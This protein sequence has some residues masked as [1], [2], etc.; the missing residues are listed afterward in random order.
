MSNSSHNDLM[1]QTIIWN[2]QIKSGNHLI[3]YD[4]KGKTKEKFEISS[5]GNI[6]FSNNKIHFCRTSEE[7]NDKIL[8]IEKNEK[9]KK[10]Y[11]DCKQYLKSFS[12]NLE[13]YGAF[14]AYRSNFFKKDKDKKNKFYR[15]DK[16]DIIK[17]GKLYIRIV[18]IKLDKE[19][20]TN[21]QNNNNSYVFQN[22]NNNIIELLPRI[23]SARELPK[24]NLK[25]MK[26]KPKNK[27]RICYENTSTIKNPLINPCKCKGSMKYIHYNCL[28]N[29]IKNKIEK[30]KNKFDIK[31]FI[32]YEKSFLNCELCKSNF[33][34]Y[35]KY[36]NNIYNIIPYYNQFKE[37][38]LFELMN[39]EGKQT[40]NIFSL[41]NKNEINIG[42]CSSN[43]ICLLE[44]TLSRF[45]SIIH[46]D[47][48]KGELYIED[49]NSRFGTLV[50]IQSNKIEINNY[51]PLRLE[52]NSVCIKI[53]RKLEKP[54]SLSCCKVNTL[55]NIEE[56]KE[57]QNQNKN[58]I[59]KYFNEVKDLDIDSI[60]NDNNIE[61]KFENEKGNKPIV[62]N[63]DDE[64]IKDEGITKDE[65][66]ININNINNKINTKKDNLIRFNNK[67]FFKYIQKNKKDKSN[68]NQK[69]HQKN[70]SISLLLNIKKIYQIKNKR[71]IN[72]IK[73][74]F[75]ENLDE[76][77]N[78]EESLFSYYSTQK[79]FNLNH[80]KKS[81]LSFSTKNFFI[82]K[83]MV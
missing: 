72:Q 38:L 17:L 57:Y 64:T 46:K 41:E 9:N 55:N 2:E 80:S 37:Y 50:L 68:E 3:D 29:C 22:N 20:T 52:I 23:N 43:D 28:L 39:K 30:V 47:K 26:I 6:F 14:M 81:I 45:H 54:K 35:I 83:Q 24:I 48:D 8:I 53:K 21:F 56:K 10:Y 34:Y 25:E 33:P 16:G 13:K 67:N 11:I 5:S 70:K 19:E 51:F 40:I 74:P 7:T 1:I 77:R 15:I 63:Y 18:E 71:N 59:N 82:K 27:C 12:V 65:I 58:D 62:I 42:R 79:K 31:K 49:N 60:D 76:Y 69:N 32:F 44:K 75:L 4:Q 61:N 36:I 78:K 66:D 73:L